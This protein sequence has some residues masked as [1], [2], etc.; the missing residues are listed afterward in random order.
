MKK[1]KIIDAI[2]LADEKYITEAAPAHAKKVSRFERRLPMRRIVA[3]SL[4]A[5]FVLLTCVLFIPY[6]TTPPS[7]ARYENSEYYDIIVKLN[8]ANFTA[9][10]QKN[11]FQTLTRSMENAIDGIFLAKGAATMDSAPNASAPIYEETTDNQV[12]GV[13]EADLVKRSDKYIYYLNGSKLYVHTVDGERSRLVSEYKIDTEGV[14][15]AYYDKW[16]LY[17]S[18]DCTT[19]TVIAPCTVRTDKFVSHVALISLD[20]TDPANITEKGRA[21]VSGS[22]GW[23]YLQPPCRRKA[24]AGDRVLRGRCGFFR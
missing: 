15:Y 3:A 6:R 24:S 7:V 17:L 1:N 8:E 12:A 13:I 23:A 2:G 20:V 4:A 16:E 21:A 9:P 18:S 10:R 11:R 5:C 19:L 14:R 22:I